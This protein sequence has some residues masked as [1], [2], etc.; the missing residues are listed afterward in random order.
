MSQVAHTTACCPG[1]VATLLQATCPRSGNITINGRA[2]S[3]D[4]CCGL[5]KNRNGNE[6]LFLYQGTYAS[7]FST[8]ASDQMVV[9]Y[10][11][12][13]ATGDKFTLCEK[14][15]IINTAT[16]SFSQRVTSTNTC[17]QGCTGTCV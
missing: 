6:G 15:G 17:P 9:S 4:G 16:V 12:T 1:L 7:P 3:V 5:S 14:R 2:V 10:S 8:I 13:C 11:G